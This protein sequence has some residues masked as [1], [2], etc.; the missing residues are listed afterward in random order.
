MRT[1]LK[2]RIRRSGVLRR[3]RNLG[4]IDLSPEEIL[5]DLTYDVGSLWETSQVAHDQQSGGTS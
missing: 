4:T 2:K 5:S 1:K 3:T